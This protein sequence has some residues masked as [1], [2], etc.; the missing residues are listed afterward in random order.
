MK[1]F[2]IPLIILFIVF[3]FIGLFFS[4]KEKTLKIIKGNNKE[5]KIDTSIINSATTSSSVINERIGANFILEF[6]RKVNEDVN[7]LTQQ[8]KPDEKISMNDYYSQ[9]NKILKK[10]KITENSQKI[11]PENLIEIAQDLS[12]IN[13]PQLFYSFHLELIEIYYK[14]G[15]AYK[16]FYNTNDPVK[17]MLLYNLIRSTLDKIKF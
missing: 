4:K 5:V 12:K 6:E 16:E 3:F 7:R 8:I 11:D 13:P 14:L 1:K 10:T 17:K 15:L 9:L 2:I